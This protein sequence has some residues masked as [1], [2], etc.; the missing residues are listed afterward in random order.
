MG[1]TDLMG[2]KKMNTKRNKIFSMIGCMAAILLAALLGLSVYVTRQ[3]K[4]AVKESGSSVRL[5]FQSD[6]LTYDGTGPLD[7][8]KGVAAEASDGSD[9]TD[10]V[11]AVVVTGNSLSEKRIQ[12]SVFDDNGEETVGERKLILENYTG[13]SIETEEKVMLN[14]ED[15]DNLISVLTGDGRLKVQDGFGKDVTSDVSWVRE[16]VDP[17]LYEIE[18][19]YVNSLQDSVEKKITAA[20][21]GAMDDLTVNLK[22]KEVRLSKGEKFDPSAYIE[23]SDPSGDGSTVQVTGEVDTQK[24]GRYGIHYSVLST[25]RTQRAQASLKIDVSEK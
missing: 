2:I 10:Q 1:V 6:E 13:P 25:D 8:M 20:V 21:N 19:T 24:P 4:D 5:H 17:G 23:I 22:E 14:A 16:K 9:V 12:Y 18:F 7:L 11:S 15:F 3:Q